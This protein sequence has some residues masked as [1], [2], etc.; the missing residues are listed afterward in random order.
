M[1]IH[2]RYMRRAIALALRAEGMTS[3][4][5]IVGAC[6]V[7][8]NKI[9]GEGFHKCAGLPH[10]E[11]NALKAA[12]LAARGSTLYVT[13]EP[14]GHFGRTPPCTDAIIESGIKAVVIAMRDPNPINNGRGIRRL[15][16]SGIEIVEGVLE[17]A[18]RA[19]NRPYIKFI[20]KG[21]PFVTLKLAESLDGRIATRLG[22]SKWITG[23]DS[24]RYGQLIRSKVDA[25]MVGVNTIIRDNPRLT[26]RVAG[27]G[28]RV[29]KK[30]LVRIVLDSGLKTL[31]NAK[32]F[33]DSKKAP[34]V[35][36]A[37][38]PVDVKK[39]RTLEERGAEV[40][41]VKSKGERVNIAGLLK[42]LAK[43]G[44]MHV[45]VEGG[46][47]VAGSILDEG[48]ADRVLFFIAPKII[49][50]RTAVPSVGGM[51]ASRIS[52][53]ISLKGIKL[54]QFKRDILI[55]GEVA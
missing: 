49:G 5:P 51:G 6:I 42:I 3:P 12:A 50:G 31:L 29:T 34:L 33:L 18:A 23:A 47:E 35:I 27:Y 11:A 24:R 10:A 19:I 8:E 7:K 22:D 55:E 46:G 1:K 28:L 52:K 25:V 13:L 36:A 9:V 32:V 45:L 48:L 54:R 4:N 53:A 2:Q 44:I 37:A 38:E 16:K 40:L 30:R 41:V 15:K 14:C 21:L 17:D 39:K 26:L 20:T 43:R